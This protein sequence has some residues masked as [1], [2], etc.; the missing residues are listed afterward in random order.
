MTTTRQRRETFRDLHRSGLFLIPNPFD[1]GSARLLEHLGFPALATTSSGFA[2]TLGRSDQHTTRTELV[3]HVRAICAAVS[4]PV[5]VDAEACFPNEPGGISETVAQ[6]AEAGAAGVS[7]EDFDPTVSAVLPIDEA[8]ERVALAVAAARSHGVVVTARAEA[9]LYGSTDLEEIIG[10]LSAYR[11]TGAD[12]LYAPGVRTAKEIG[13]LVDVGLP[14]N[15]LAMPG[16]PNVAELRALGVRRIST[17]G[18]LAWSAYGSFARAATELRD[19]G[20][21]SYSDEALDRST[22]K[23]AFADHTSSSG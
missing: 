22:R 15:V 7:I 6:F 10:R 21:Y 13:R 23:T 17:G 3:E 1:V 4:L 14:V 19:H 11:D 16:V 12:V 9:L 8:T 18:A 5:N 20:T 2:A